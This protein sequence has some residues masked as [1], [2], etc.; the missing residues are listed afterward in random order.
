[1]SWSDRGECPCYSILR[2]LFTYSYQVLWWSAFI[3]IWHFPQYQSAVNWVK[4]KMGTTS[5]P[6]LIQK[7]QITPK[8]IFFIKWVK[9][10]LTKSLLPRSFWNGNL[11]SEALVGRCYC[12]VSQICGWWGEGGTIVIVTWVFKMKGLYSRSLIGGLIFWYVHNQLP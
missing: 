6:N 9:I 8:G 10:M 2:H 12:C 7:N 1:M 3:F 4:N 5:S 11:E